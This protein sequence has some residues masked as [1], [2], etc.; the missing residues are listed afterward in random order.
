MEAQAGSYNGLDPELSWALRRLWSQESRLW[1]QDPNPQLCAFIYPCPLAHPYGARTWLGILGSPNQPTLISRR[2]SRHLRA[3]SSGGS[4][5]LCEL[6]HTCSGPHPQPREPHSAAPSGHAGEPA[7]NR[8]G[9]A[10]RGV[11]MH[12]SKEEVKTKSRADL[13]SGLN[14]KLSSKL[15]SSQIASVGLLHFTHFVGPF[16]RG[17]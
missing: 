3:A 15:I 12:I 8:S 14:H 9:E 4:C 10:G 13:L 2:R 11:E 6:T 7:L 16:I 5:S 17:C 1:V